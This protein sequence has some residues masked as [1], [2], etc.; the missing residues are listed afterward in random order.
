MDQAISNALRRK[1]ELEREL[2]RI[3]QFIA[4]YEEFAGTSAAQSGSVKSDAGNNHP[5][6]EVSPPPRGRR[7]RPPEVVKMVERILKDVG[8]PMTRGEIASALAARDVVLPAE[9]K[10]RYI[11]TIMWRNGD[12]FESV[13]GGYWLKGVPVPQTDHE[14]LAL[15]LEGQPI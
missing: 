1:A 13:E 11:G 3:E 10:P 2:Q 12:V 6:G 15:K 8:H 5:D 14:A 4:L 9:D 7:V